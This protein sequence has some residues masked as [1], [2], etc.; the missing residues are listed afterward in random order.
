MK[1]KGGDK[2]RIKPLGWWESLDNNE[3][4][5]YY[6]T[7]SILPRTVP[8]EIVLRFENTEHTVERVGDLDSFVYICF[9]VGG[10]EFVCDFHP[11]MLEIVE[12][13]DKPKMGVE[14][15]EQHL[16]LTTKSSIDFLN[17]S[18]SI[19]EERA[20]AYDSP[21]GERSM[22]KTVRAFNIITGH[23]IKESEGWLFQQILK[24]VRQWQRKDYHEDSALD[25]VSYSSLKAEALAKGK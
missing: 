9:D 7:G 15:T 14:L 17:E 5:Y 20:V 19:Q 3:M 13:I 1:F 11:N 16:P 12:L 8:K 4:Y 21:S 2:V 25:C 18:K 6:Q 23:N 10:A 24:D 22:E